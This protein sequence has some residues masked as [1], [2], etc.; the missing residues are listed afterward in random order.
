M[1]ASGHHA[2]VIAVL[3]GLLAGAWRAPPDRHPPERPPSIARRARGPRHLTD[4]NH[5]D[6]D[7]LSALP[8]IGRRTAQR[9]VE[10]RPFASVDD[11]L[12]VRGIGP[13]KLSRLRPWV[14]VR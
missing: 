10:A 6:L 2:A 5:A 1:S 9:I 7:A 3:L 12:R 8:G 11:L 13:R 4:V 14:T